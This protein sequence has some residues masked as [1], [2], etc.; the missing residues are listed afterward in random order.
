M[1]EIIYEAAGLVT[2]SVRALIYLLSSPNFEM[3]P[4]RKSVSQLFTQVITPGLRDLVQIRWAPDVNR[5]SNL[6]IFKN[7]GPS[8]TKF[9]QIFTKIKLKVFGFDQNL[10]L[11]I[12]EMWFYAPFIFVAENSAALQAY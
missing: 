1:C 9:K 5:C 12:R 3:G 6:K 4:F 7:I 10:C 11:W 2:E 8:S